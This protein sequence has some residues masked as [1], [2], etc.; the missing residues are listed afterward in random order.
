MSEIVELVMRKRVL[1]SGSIFVSASVMLASHALAQEIPGARYLSDPSY[2][3]Y[4]GQFDGR[5]A[6]AFAD[7]RGNTYDSSGALLSHFYDQSERLAQSLEYGITDDVAVSLDENYLPFDKRTRTSVAGTVTSR[8]SSGFTDPTLGITWR[9]IDQD[10]ERG[11]SPLN[12]D[13]SGT[14]SPDWIGARSA[15]A[16]SGGNEGRGGQ[17]GSVGL[18]LSEVWPAFTLYGSAAAVFLGSRQINNPGSGAISTRNPSNEWQLGLSSQFRASDA[19]SFNAGVG[20]T[21]GRGTTVITSGSGV[22][23][24]ENPAAT[25]DLHLAANYAFIPQDLVGSLTFGHSFSGIAHAVFPAV[26][27]NDTTTRGRQENVL[28]VQLDYAFR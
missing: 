10:A 9:A 4:A 6:F 24:F 18:A 21:F 3:P 17:S 7:G 19:V 28:G 13:L 12:L 14:Y 26:P 15:T 22:E 8:S 1:F 11:G 16:T 25:T 27:A 2:L 23:R 5:T 20:E